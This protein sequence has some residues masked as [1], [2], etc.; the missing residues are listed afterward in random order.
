MEKELQFCSLNSELSIFCLPQ[1]DRIIGELLGGATWKPWELR[2]KIIEPI[3]LPDG[4]A[5]RGFEIK[6][7][8]D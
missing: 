6:K 4:E 8:I 5:A 3:S 2:E 7:K 1:F